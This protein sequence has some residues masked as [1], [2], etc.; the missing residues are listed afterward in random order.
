MSVL[1][2]T[3]PRNDPCF[4]ALFLALAMF[5][6]PDRYGACPQGIDV[7]SCTLSRSA[8]GFAA[9]ESVCATRLC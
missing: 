3:V 9:I 4:A 1:D 5:P 6:H 8:L 7:A 2:D